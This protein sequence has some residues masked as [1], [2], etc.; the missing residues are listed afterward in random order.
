MRR[1]SASSHSDPFFAAGFIP[2]NPSAPAK[3]LGCPFS[4]ATPIASSNDLGPTAADMGR[5]AETAI[6]ADTIA[7]FIARDT[8]KSSGTNRPFCICLTVYV[9]SVFSPKAAFPLRNRCRDLPGEV[10]ER[11]TL[12]FCVVCHAVSGNSIPNPIDVRLGT[13]F[14]NFAASTLLKSS[15][16]TFRST[17]LTRTS[18]D[19]TKGPFFKGLAFR[20]ANHAVRGARKL[21]AGHKHRPRGDEQCPIFQQRQKATSADC[22]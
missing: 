14:R 11:R 6:A 3:S 5:H 16:S 19:S 18:G 7:F 8:F 20:P 13:G 21:S 2:A 4:T 22:A 10:F 12:A 1:F 9:M 15:V 17:A